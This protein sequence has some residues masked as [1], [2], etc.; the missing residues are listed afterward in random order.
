MGH[1]NNW[2][3]WATLSLLCSNVNF[4]SSDCKAIAMYGMM[5]SVRPTST[6]CVFKS[7][8]SVVVDSTDTILNVHI[9]LDDLCQN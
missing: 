2:Y 7:L 8:I 9:D 5:L 3:Y 1:T 4:C 6:F